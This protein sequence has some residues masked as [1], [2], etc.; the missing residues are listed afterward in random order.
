MK[1]IKNKLIL[2]SDNSITP[3]LIEIK[4]AAMSD[5]ATV[6]YKNNFILPSIL[7]KYMAYNC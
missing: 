5:D 2:N 7:Y 1:A 3:R 4:L 6:I